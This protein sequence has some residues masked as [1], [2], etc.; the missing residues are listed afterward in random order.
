MA[1]II[2]FKTGDE[3]VPG[4]EWMENNRDAFDRVMAIGFDHDGDIRF[5][6]NGLTV[7]ECIYLLEY[8][9]HDLLET[10]GG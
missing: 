9:K 7:M 5:G 8:I 4:P 2:D 3:H 6:A 1:D 10:Y